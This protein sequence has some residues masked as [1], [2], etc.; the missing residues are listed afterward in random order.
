M[1]AR[2]ARSSSSSGIAAAGAARAARRA[3][4]RSCCSVR[5]SAGTAS[6]RRPSRR[7]R[8]CRSGDDVRWTRRWRRSRCST[9][10]SSTTIEVDVRPGRLRHDD[11]DLRRAPARRSGSRRPSRSTATTY[12]RVG[13]RLKGNSSLRGL[14]AARGRRRCRRRRPRPG[15]I[16][17]G[18]RC[19]A[20]R[21]RARCRGS[22]RLDKFVDGQATR[23]ST[24]LVVRSN[25]TETSLNEAVALELLEP[26]RPGLAAG[27]ATPFSVNGGDAVLRLIIENPDDDVGRGQLRRRR[28]AVQ[29]REHAATGQLPRRRP[30]GL[31]RDLRPGGRQGRHR[32][33]AAHRRSSI[34]QRRRRRRP[35][36]P[37]S[38]E[39][40]DVERSRPTS[41]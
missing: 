10:S 37:S 34:H 30:G 24:D 4:S 17:A 19:A 7:H 32:P 40:L 21:A 33:D 41:R 39:R 1:P 38:P 36:R 5:G 6:Q 26:G 27:G 9:S 31:R 22:I 12:E 14:C 13:I 28:R 15:G 23:A 11:R 2:A 20:G 35:S 18:R 16:E 8:G 29:G 25:N 3:S